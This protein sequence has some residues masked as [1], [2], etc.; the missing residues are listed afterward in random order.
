MND[1]TQ[2]G[3]SGIEHPVIEGCHLSVFLKTLR[4]SVAKFYFITLYHPKLYGLT[5]KKAT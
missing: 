4:P 1:V 3:F 2:Q 5:S